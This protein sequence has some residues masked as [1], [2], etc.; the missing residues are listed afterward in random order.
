MAAGDGLPEF[1]TPYNTSEFEALVAAINAHCRGLTSQA[2]VV[3]ADLRRLLP[4]AKNV[5]GR[6]YLGGLDLHLAARQVARQFSQMAGAFNSAAAAGSKALQY[7]HG[8]F[9]QPAGSHSSG[10]SFDARG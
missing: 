3:S 1:V 10:R 5:G 2:E 6:A 9:V 7:Y 4:K 8:T